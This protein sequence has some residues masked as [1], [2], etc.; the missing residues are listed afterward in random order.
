[1]FV[2]RHSQFDWSNFAR[3]RASRLATSTNA[4]LP[5]VLFT[6]LFNQVEVFFTTLSFSIVTSRSRTIMSSDR[7][8]ERGFHLSSNT[9]ELISPSRWSNSHIP[10]CLEH[11]FLFLII[12]PAYYIHFTCLS[13]LLIRMKGM[14]TQMIREIK[15]VTKQNKAAL[16]GPNYRLG[17]LTCADFDRSNRNR[18][19]EKFASSDVKSWSNI[20]LHFFLT[21]ANIFV[22]I[23]SLSIADKKTYSS[24]YHSV[25]D[26][27]LELFLSR[28]IKWDHLSTEVY[29]QTWVLALVIRSLDQWHM[30]LLAQ[31]DSLTGR[32]LDYDYHIQITQSNEMKAKGKC[33]RW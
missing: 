24:D 28:S 26:V 2:V 5:L 16:I 32:S 29:R 3:R 11:F 13:I 27:Q 9:A 23:A 22:P 17:T 12:P 25:A 31:G 4:R 18:L 10:R 1:M 6:D 20:V 21:R 8:G 14:T 19:E 33:L 15:K 7:E 30:L